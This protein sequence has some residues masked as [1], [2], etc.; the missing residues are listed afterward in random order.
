LRFKNKKK[1][2][3]KREKEK[4]KE[5]RNPQLGLASP[6]DP[7]THYARDLVPTFAHEG[8]I[9]MMSHPVLEGK[10]NANHVRASIITHVH[11]DYI[12]GHHHTM[13]KVNSGKVL[14]LHQ[15][16]QDIHRV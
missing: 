5:K 2:K 3:E 11:I 8:V 14:Y 12:I 15:Y 16:V 1:R 4:E 7:P 9:R 6:D 10:P 13:L